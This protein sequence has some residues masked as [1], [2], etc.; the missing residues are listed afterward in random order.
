MVVTSEIP[1]FLITLEWRRGVVVMTAA[2]LHSI[3]LIV[4]DEIRQVS[5]KKLNFAKLTETRSEIS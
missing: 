2:Q 3:R 4:I 1:I 5:R